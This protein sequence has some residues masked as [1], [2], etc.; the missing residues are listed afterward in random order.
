MIDME[1]LMAAAYAHHS[2]SEDRS[3]EDWLTME[4]IDPDQFRE[5]VEYVGAH[6]PRGKPDIPALGFGFALGWV[7]HRELGS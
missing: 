5:F 7:A 2:E 6:D 1:K 4:G 3:I